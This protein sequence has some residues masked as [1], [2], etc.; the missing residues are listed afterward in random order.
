[1]PGWSCS[2]PRA[3]LQQVGS[4]ADPDET[5]GIEHQD[6][7]NVFVDHQVQRVD[8]VIAGTNAEYLAGRDGRDRRRGVEVATEEFVSADHP[9]ACAPVSSTTG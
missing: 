2:R 6:V 7:F 5:T 9:E 1:M 3:D 4:G 8:G